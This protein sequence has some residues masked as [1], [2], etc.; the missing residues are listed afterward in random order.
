MLASPPFTPFISQFSK[1]PQIHMQLRH[2]KRNMAQTIKRLS[3]EPHIPE[4]VFYAGEIDFQVGEAFDT[5]QVQDGV[6]EGRDV[7]GEVGDGLGG[8]PGE[9]VLEVVVLAG[10][11]VTIYLLALILDF[12]PKKKGGLDFGFQG[13][14]NSVFPNLAVVTIVPLPNPTGSCNPYIANRMIISN[15]A[16]PPSAALSGSASM[17]MSSA[18]EAFVSCA[19]RRRGLVAGAFSSPMPIVQLKSRL[20]SPRSSS[21]IGR[22]LASC[23]VACG[24]AWMRGLVSLEGEEALAGVKG[25][26]QVIENSGAVEL[27]G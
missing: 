26:S 18:T 3:S 24:K 15:A 6:E 2:P 12:L 11:E 10:E 16:L 21:V 22:F 14:Y 9:D 20:S 23:S 19:P 4:I 8:D 25:Y 5:P 1:T 13:T 17:Y 7:A 27:L